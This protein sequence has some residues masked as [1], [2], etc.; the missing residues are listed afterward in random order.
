M[1]FSPVGQRLSFTSLVAIS[2]SPTQISPDNSTEVQYNP[3]C[4]FCQALAG[5]PPN[6]VADLLPSGFG[7]REYHDMTPASR[8][9]FL[10]NGHS[11][12]LRWDLSH[13]TA[14]EFS[15]QKPCILNVSS[16]L[17]AS[18]PHSSCKCKGFRPQT[19]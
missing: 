12:G 16:E 14:N 5:D 10:S 1:T 15:Y 17:N 3:H 19:I 13:R 4:S 18:N 7:G 11:P 8:F 2:S 9:G 6:P